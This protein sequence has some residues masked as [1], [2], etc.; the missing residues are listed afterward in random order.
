MKWYWLVDCDNVKPN[1][2]VAGTGDLQGA[3]DWQLWQGKPITG[4]RPD[5]WVQALTEEE[6]GDPDDVLQTF[7]GVPIFSPRLRHSLE[8][9][10]LGAIQYLSIR[11]LR[12]DGANIE[13]FCV[14]N[15]LSVVDC[16]DTKRSVI[17]RFENDYFLPERRGRISGVRLPVLRRS[18]LWGH[19]L[20][21]CKGYEVSLY[22]SSR[23][24]AVFEGGG[25]T[26]YSFKEVDIAEEE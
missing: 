1:P 12:R 26:G 24:R 4:W 11:V 19:D 14:A 25:F 9:A 17:D 20:V 7:L 22:A 16:L 23:F 2:Y 21:R 13:G 18:A 10:Q 15:V 8:T 6:D 3:E 5:S